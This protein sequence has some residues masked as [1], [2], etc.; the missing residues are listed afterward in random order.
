MTKSKNIVG[1]KSL[2]DPK[3]KATIEV[4]D[5]FAKQYGNYTFEHILQFQLM[6][7]T[8]YLKKKAKILDIGCA[9]GRDVEYL[10]E[11][12]FNITGI[13]LSK[14][15]IK[16]A[17]KKFK[18]KFKHMDMAQMSFKDASFDA[19]WCHATLCHVKKGSAVSVLKEFYRAL[20]KGGVVYI[21]L[22]SGKG[23]GMVAFSETGNMERFF[24]FYELDEL[25][26]LMKKAGFSVLKAYSEKDG[27]SGTWLN[28]FAKKE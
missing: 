15:L 12:G 27:Y 25:V 10:S 19:I 2:K 24:A 13:D 17:K 5:K 1:F 21:G 4:Y 8:N 7:F 6:Q 16:E 11:E 9:S 28:V 14:N 23:Q 20:K 22:R 26:T 3:I 18:G